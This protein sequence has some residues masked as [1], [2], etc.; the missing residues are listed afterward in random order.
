MTKEQKVTVYPDQL[1]IGLQAERKDIPNIQE[2]GRASKIYN[3]TTNLPGTKEPAESYMA[4]KQSWI[5]QYLLWYH[6]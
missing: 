4:G 1:M 5:I 6:R 3:M 2:D